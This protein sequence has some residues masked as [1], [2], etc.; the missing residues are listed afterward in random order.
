MKKMCI[1]LLLAAMLVCVFAPG[2]S[3]RSRPLWMDQ[4]QD[5]ADTPQ[6]E[7]DPWVDVDYIS[8]DEPSDSDGSTTQSD[9]FDSLHSVWITFTKLF[10]PEPSVQ[11]GSPRGE[12]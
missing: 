6:G 7:A 1:G 4:L 9:L 8:P 3:A 11:P 2:V 10:M 12:K 5:H